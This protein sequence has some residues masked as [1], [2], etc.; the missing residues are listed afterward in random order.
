VQQRLVKAVLDHAP[1]PYTNDELAAVAAHCSE[2]ED[3]AQRVERAMRKVIAARLFS[4]RIGQTFDAIV[5]GAG[6]KGTYVRLLHPP[7]EGRVVRGEA[8]MDVGDRVRVR[9]VHVDPVHGHIDLERA[10]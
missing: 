1:Q 7:A 2:R 9:L 5:T 10:H 8:G 3:E 6:N 4:D